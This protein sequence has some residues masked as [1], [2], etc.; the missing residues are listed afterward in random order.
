M[1]KFYISANFDLLI[2]NWE[3]ANTKAHAVKE[4]TKKKLLCQLR[5]Y[6]RFCDTF[7]VEYFTCYNRQLCRFGQFLSRIFES[8]DAVGN[9][10][11]GIRT[12]MALLGLEIP[13][14]QDRQMHMFM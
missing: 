6:E 7:Q 5:A 11:S 1:V 12:C 2:L 14:T 10:I 4:S 8:P 9:Y 3:V 13:T